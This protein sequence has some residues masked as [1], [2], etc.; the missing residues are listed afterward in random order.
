MIIQ[1]HIIRFLKQEH[2]VNK[3]VRRFREGGVSLFPDLPPIEKILFIHAG[4]VQL[5][6][7]FRIPPGVSLGRQQ[8]GNENRQNNRQ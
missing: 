5:N 6:Q 2:P 3:I 4:I 7:Q 1:L 8:R